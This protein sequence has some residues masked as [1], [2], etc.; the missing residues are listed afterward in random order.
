MMEPIEWS[1][2][3]AYLKSKYNACTPPIHFSVEEILGWGLGVPSEF[4]LNVLLK[5][6]HIDNVEYLELLYRKMQE[7][8]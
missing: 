7:S 8:L 5:C 6:G 2:Y 3:E 1:S 4:L